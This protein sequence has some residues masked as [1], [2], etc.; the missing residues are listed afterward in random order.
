MKGD[1]RPLVISHRTQMGE[2]PEN[3]LAGIEVALAQHVDAIEIDVRATADGVPVLM[4]DA[5]LARTT[6]LDRPLSDLTLADLDAVRVV[7][8]HGCLEPQRVPTL[9]EA[10]A[11]IGGRALLCIEVK[12]PGLEAAVARAVRAAGATGWCWI[13]AF[14]PAVVTACHAELPEVRVALNAGPG[15]E[16]RYGYDSPVE[17]AARGGSAAVSLAHS[18]VDAAT[19]EAAHLRGL[20]VFTWTVDEPADIAR[21]LEAGVDGVCSNLPSRVRAALEGRE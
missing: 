17:A 14:D 19:V 3:T 18:L 5:S 1:A 4:H 8:P 10:L 16:A 20:M 2:C 7:D 15:S 6:G 12:D 13:W 11:A 9:D 21:V